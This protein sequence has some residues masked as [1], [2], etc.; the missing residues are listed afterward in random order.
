MLTNRLRRTLA[1]FVLLGGL[2]GAAGS[3]EANAYYCDDWCLQ[4]QYCSLE[5]CQC[6]ACWLGC[7]DADLQG[8]WGHQGHN[9]ICFYYGCG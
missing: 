7:S 8:C 2:L 9:P 6:Y 1:V 3:L 4:G 5:W